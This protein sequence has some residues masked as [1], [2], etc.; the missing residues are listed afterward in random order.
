MH[1]VDWQHAFDRTRFALYSACD[2]ELDIT[3][4]ESINLKAE[5]NSSIVALYNIDV[6][7]Q[8]LLSMVSRRVSDQ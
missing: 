1:E 8:V 4:Y 2:F 7:A 6:E 5:R 3:C